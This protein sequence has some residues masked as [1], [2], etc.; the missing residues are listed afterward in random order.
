M[1][2]IFLAIEVPPSV[3]SLVTRHISMVQQQ[4]S[5][6][7]VAWVPEDNLHLT[8]RFLGDVEH[9]QIPAIQE[10]ASRAVAGQS[11]F[12]ISISEAGSFPP[13]GLPRVLWLG[14]DDPDLALDRLHAR[15]DA[16]C[17][18]IGFF[19]DDKPFRPHLTIGR[20]RHRSA[21]RESDRVHREIAFE[22]TL[23]TVSAVEVLQS[24]LSQQ[25]AHHYLLS[26]HEM[27]VR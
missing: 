23:L 10:A 5:N 16:E 4:L 8:L 14:V 1:P 22:R 27:P 7:P 24:K 19:N 17:A 3:K 18:G 12:D 13:E 25:G 9:G 21:A 2:R 6:T 26:Q 15:V 20:I 11:P